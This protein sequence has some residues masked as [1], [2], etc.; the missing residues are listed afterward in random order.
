M[1]KFTLIE[2]LVVIAIIAI[3]ASMLLPALSKARAAAQTISCV[4]NQKQIGLAFVMYANDYNDF[5]V[6]YNYI[7]A[8]GST[9]G[10]PTY[11]HTYIQG[12]DPAMY[13]T[14]DPIAKSSIWWCPMHLGMEPNQYIRADR[15]LQNVSYGYNERFSYS[16]VL[17]SQIKSPSQMLVTTEIS[18]DSL[19]SGYYAQGI[20]WNLVGRHGGGTPSRSEGTATTAFGDGSSRSMPTKAGNY[21]TGAAPYW[22]D[23]LPWDWDLNGI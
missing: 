11:I 23:D 9:Y 1:K 7:A 4:N 8:N 2:L 15:Y 5:M 20:W 19:T 17:I 22:Q 10:Y 6:P 16:P 14:S 21:G 12:E 3:L 18:M 13:Y